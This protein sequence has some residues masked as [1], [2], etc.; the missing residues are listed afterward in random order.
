M[1]NILLSFLLILL[2]NSSKAGQQVNFTGSLF[3]N[4]SNHTITVQL[5][6][7]NTSTNGSSGCGNQ[8]LD[9]AVIR[10]GLQWNSQL[11]TLQSWNFLPAAGTGLDALEYFT[12]GNGTADDIPD[13]T[14]SGTRTIGSKTFSTLDYTRSTNLCDNTIHLGCEET[15]V[16]FQVVFSIPADS[17]G[18]YDYTHPN[19]NTGYPNY[20][21]EFN[22]GTSAPSNSFKQILFVANRPYDTPGNSCPAGSTV[23]NNVSNV[24]NDAKSNVFVNTQSP[25]PVQLINF[26]VV[27]NNGNVVLSW[28]SVVNAAIATYEIQKRTTGGFNTL[29]FVPPGVS[30]EYQYIDK[31]TTRSETVYYRVKLKTN[32]GQ[33]LYSEIR[34]INLLRRFEML[35]Y[36][37][38]NTGSF[39]VLLPDSKGNISADLIDFS[40]KVVKK[41]MNI[42]ANQTLYVTG[43][44]KGVYTFKINCKETGETTFQKITIQ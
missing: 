12:G 21:A 8:N 36:P 26:S 33:I 3:Y 23:G 9:L 27:R 41:W 28:Q 29:A 18:K 20:I 40:G 42:K 31:E 38:P 10:F 6:I 35:V 5:L 13:A 32:N 7:T 2:F 15:F 16:L 1:K 25:L 39:N 4:S 43:I 34:S 22:D 37:N 17:A 11:L 24:P 30:E 14:V 19:D 44:N